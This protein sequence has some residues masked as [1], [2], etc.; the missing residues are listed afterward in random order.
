MLR[1]IVLPG[2]VTFSATT[3]LAAEFA[4]TGPSRETKLPPEKFP[5]AV[6]MA[7]D[8]H[9]ATMQSDVFPMMPYP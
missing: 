6:K 1:H 9:P 8:L 3:A 7:F 4:V 2:P 5:D